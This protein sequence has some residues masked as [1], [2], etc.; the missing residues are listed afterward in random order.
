M[1][2][3]TLYEHYRAACREVSDCGTE[4]WS[5]LDAAARAEWNRTAELV[6]QD[7]DNETPDPEGGLG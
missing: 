5:E 4:T 7:R 6:Q 1:N 2:G 3:Q